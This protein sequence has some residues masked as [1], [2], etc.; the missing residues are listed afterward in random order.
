MSPLHI[1][2]DLIAEQSCHLSL[3][4]PTPQRRLP[5]DEE[6][7]EDGGGGKGFLTENKVMAFGALRPSVMLCVTTPIASK[8]PYGSNKQGEYYNKGT[9]ALGKAQKGTLAALNLS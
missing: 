1:E 7:N 9:V 8:Y 5:D 6:S 3:H 4:R 2:A